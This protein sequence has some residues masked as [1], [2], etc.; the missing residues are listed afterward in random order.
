[1]LLELR[2]AIERQG[3]KWDEYLNN[4]K[5]TEADVTK[6]FRPQAERRVK[7]ALVLRQLAQDNKIAVT[8]DELE[9]EIKKLEE[10]YSGNPQSLQNIQ[11]PG[12][13]QYTE[14]ILINRK[15]MAVLRQTAVADT[16]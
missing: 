2:Q 8:P 16:K 1:M 13:R 14:N 11:S 4:I 12:Y 6:D 3:M 5:R 9:A 10:M 7:G 15:V